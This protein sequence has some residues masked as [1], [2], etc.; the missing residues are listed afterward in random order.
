MHLPA[1][2]GPVTGAL[3]A[4]LRCDDP[5]LL[6]AVPGRD[7]SSDPLG[8]DDLQLAL[9]ICYE[10]HY[11]GFADVAARWEWEPELVRLRGRFETELL[12]A[13]RQD[14]RVPDGESTVAD[15]LRELVDG[16]DGPQLSRYLQQHANREQFLEFVMLR[17]VYQLKEADPHTWAIPRL[18]GRAK[19]ALVEIQTDE[20]GGGDPRHMHSELYRRLLRSLDLDDSYGAYVDVV[21]AIT[22]ALSNV[23]SLFGLHRE[24]RGALVGHLAAY[25]MTSSGPCRR[26]AKGLRRVAGDTADGTFF[27]AHI[28]ADALHE[29]LAAHDLCGG[30]AADEPEL[31]EDIVF[32]AAA[33]LHVDRRFATYV[34]DRW[35]DGRSSLR[36]DDDELAEVS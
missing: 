35:Q 16:D 5:A 15:R 2:R 7:A 24:L 13:L 3:I 10:L 32:G 4:A 23:M 36:A 33:C 19:A 27:D 1:A 8:D 11:R 6:A 29:Q 26:Y 31:T 18:G 9:W 14:V 17:S 20:Y 30:L 21:P 12:D 22:L 34:L 28:T 25:E